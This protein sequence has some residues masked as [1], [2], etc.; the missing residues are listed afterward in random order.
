MLKMNHKV[1]FLTLNFENSSI[2]LFM[3]ENN[4]CE[5]KAV[6]NND[7]YFILCICLFIYVLRHSSKEWFT[8][9][10]RWFMNFKVTLKLWILNLFNI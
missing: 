8:F 2:L 3:P 10:V 7:S 6:D 5:T 4:K 1:Q 9:S